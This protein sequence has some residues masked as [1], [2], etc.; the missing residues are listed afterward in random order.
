ML[1]RTELCKYS[2]A[3][4]PTR[5]LGRS[6]EVQTKYDLFLEDCKNRVGFVEEMKCM[7]QKGVYHFVQN[8]FP[9]HTTSNI[10]HWVCWYGRDTDPKKIVGELKKSNDIITYWKNHSY[11]MSIQEIN[12]IHVFIQR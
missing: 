11:N 6:K 8:D 4:P 12:H 2:I 9:Y 5:M 7:L 3:S 1:S 10:E